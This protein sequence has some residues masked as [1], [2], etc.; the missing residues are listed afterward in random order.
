MASKM[1]MHVGD[2]FSFL[3]IDFVTKIKKAYQEH[4]KKDLIQANPLA[5]AGFVC[6]I[7]LVTFIVTKS[8][9]D[10]PSCELCSDT[11]LSSLGR[12]SSSVGAGG[13]PKIS[14]KNSVEDY[15]NIIFWVR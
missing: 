7:S 5:I 13:C 10:C 8:L 4:S 11:E 3:S 2:V 14:E 1:L 9:C 15:S 6:P 12:G